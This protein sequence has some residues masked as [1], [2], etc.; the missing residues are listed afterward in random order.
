MKITKKHIGAA[1]IASSISLFV[2]IPILIKAKNKN[3]NIVYV[4]I[5]LASVQAIIGSFLISGI[6]LSSL[7]PKRKSK[8]NRPFPGFYKD[9]YNVFSYEEAY[10]AEK[11]MFSELHNKQ[12]KENYMQSKSSNGQNL[13]VKAVHIGSDK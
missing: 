3:K 13:A 1:V 5:T 8:E 7:L 12:R 4:I 2:L 9:E 11:K 10:E 6:D